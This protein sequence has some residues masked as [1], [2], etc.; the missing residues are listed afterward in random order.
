MLR[1]DPGIFS[2]RLRDS[3]EINSEEA[4]EG[5]IVDELT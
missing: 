3:S 5:E 1:S 2:A 4:A